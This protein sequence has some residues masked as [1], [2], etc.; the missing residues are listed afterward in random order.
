MKG[1]TKYYCVDDIWFKPQTKTLVI[2][3][4]NK[5]YK[6]TNLIGTMRIKTFS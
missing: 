3:K 1:F 2:E 4:G 5:M 6:D